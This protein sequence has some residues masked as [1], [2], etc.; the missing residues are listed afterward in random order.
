MSEHDIEYQ[1]ANDSYCHT[2]EETIPNA[3]VQAHRETAVPEPM[4][5][6]T[7]Y[8]S[9]E[10]LPTLKG[11]EHPVTFEVHSNGVYCTAQFL[12][13]EFFEEISQISPEIY[14][15]RRLDGSDEEIKSGTVTVTVADS[16]G[17]TFGDQTFDIQD[18]AV[19]PGYGFVPK[20]RLDPP[21]RFD[22]IDQIT[23]TVDADTGP[24]QNNE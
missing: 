7:Q 21:R 10:M 4:D 14:V 23:I 1:N 16:S 24:S 3:E 13:R 18:L 15:D 11:D 20:I 5:F 9:E 19:K 8:E 17:N 22:R 6:D 12:N 2:C